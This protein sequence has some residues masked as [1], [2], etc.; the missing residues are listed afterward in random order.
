VRMGKGGS[1]YW[2]TGH[3]EKAPTR[4]RVRKVLTHEKNKSAYIYTVRELVLK[5][6]KRGV[7]QKGKGLKDV[8]PGPPRKRNDGGAKELAFLSKKGVTGKAEVNHLNEIPE[9]EGRAI[10]PLGAQIKNIKG[11]ERIPKPLPK[12]KG[13][14]GE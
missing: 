6:R 8:V 9:K 3:R 1:L 2:K 13:R 11:E 10:V 7:P 5:D 12:G 14:P 4:G